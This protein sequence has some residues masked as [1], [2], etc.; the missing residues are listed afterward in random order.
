MKKHFY[1]ILVLIQVLGFTLN[2]SAQIQYSWRNDQN[3]TSGQW[4]NS[5][6]WW[7]GSAS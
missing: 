3:P 4:N 1:L 6:Y 5:N 7:N 2:L